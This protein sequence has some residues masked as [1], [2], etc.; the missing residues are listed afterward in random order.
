MNTLQLAGSLP[1]DPEFRRFVS[2]WMV[3]VREP[4]IDEA[5]QFI[6]AACD[7]DSRRQLATDREAEQ[8]FHRFIRRPFTAWRDQQQL[9]LRRAA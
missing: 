6:R 7:I 1:R 2:Q 3:P 9:Q 8:R 5:A 4:T